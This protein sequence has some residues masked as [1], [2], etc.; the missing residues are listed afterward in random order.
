MSMMACLRRLVAAHGRLVRHTRLDD[1]ASPVGRGWRVEHPESVLYWFPTVTGNGLM[2][3]GM[4][5]EQGC[6]TK[7]GRA[8]IDR[9]PL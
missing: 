5:D 1:R 6:I 4:I 9:Y 3:R 2:A 8:A 7:L